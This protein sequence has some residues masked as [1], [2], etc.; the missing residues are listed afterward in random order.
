MAHSMLNAFHQLCSKIISN[1][2][3]HLIRKSTV[4]TFK[5][6]RKQSTCFDIKNYKRREIKSH[7][8]YLTNSWSVALSGDSMILVI[9]SEVMAR[10]LAAEVPPLDA[11]L[12]SQSSFFF[13]LFFFKL[14]AISGSW[15]TV[16]FEFFVTSGKDLPG[17]FSVI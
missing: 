8:S 7:P 17:Y 3:L 1:S 4:I 6:P 14:Y 2:L 11:S 12:I 16:S 15:Q 13:H 10:N 9:L 5:P